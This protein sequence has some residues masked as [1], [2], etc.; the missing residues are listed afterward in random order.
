M[1]Q[2][3][4]APRGPGR[5]SE[6]RSHEISADGERQHRSTQ[7]EAIRPRVRQHHVEAMWDAGGH[8]GGL[9]ERGQTSSG[10]QVGV[11]FVPGLHKSAISDGTS[12][13][14][15]T[16]LDGGQSFNRLQD[17]QKDWDVYAQESF[18]GEADAAEVNSND[19]APPAGLPKS[20][21]RQDPIKL[22]TGH[23]GQPW[24]S[25][26]KDA[27]LGLLK[28]IVRGYFTC[29]YREWDDQQWSYPDDSM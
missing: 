17:I 21:A 15:N 27:S 16:E 20:K 29:Y 19:Q 13:D 22:V 9:A 14:F 6:F 7:R 10:Q 26:I 4:A 3:K 2:G 1:E 28:N 24:L 18:G 23:D 11:L 8:L 5:V 25:D 12:H